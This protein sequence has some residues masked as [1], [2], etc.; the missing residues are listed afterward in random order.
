MTDEEWRPVVGW[1]EY[2][3][4]SDRGQVRSLD[5]TRPNPLTGGMS[6]HAGK[7]IPPRMNRGGYP[8]VNLYRPGY[9][10]TRP[11]HRLVAEAFIPNP[12]GLPIVLHG[13][14]GSLDNSVFNLRWGTNSDNMKDRIRD[15]T[16]YETNKTHCPKGH[17]YSP[18][19][20]QIDSH[21]DNRTHRRCKKCRSEQGQKRRE[22][23]TTEGLPSGDP[24]HGTRNGYNAYGCRCDGCRAANSEFNRKRKEKHREEEV[25]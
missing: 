17:E 10:R 14:S 21:G 15:G 8:Q 24:R 3:E 4:V 1:E 18:E 16:C 12:E 25:A 5:R 20:T 6:V 7:L 22:K 13:E 9:R 23:L 11:V 19:N 2:Y